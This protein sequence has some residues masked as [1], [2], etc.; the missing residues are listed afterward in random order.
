MANVI[1]NMDTMLTMVMEIVLQIAH[2]MKFWLMDFA[3]VF[4]ATFE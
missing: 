3:N 2:L 4:R 1:A